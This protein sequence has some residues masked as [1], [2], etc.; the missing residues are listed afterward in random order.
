MRAFTIE[1]PPKAGAPQAPL[2][3][4]LA[5][6]AGLALASAIGTASA[7]WLLKLLLG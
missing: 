4:R 5:W 3:V 7:A 2:K 6:F 1:P